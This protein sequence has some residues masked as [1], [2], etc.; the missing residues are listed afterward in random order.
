VVKSVTGAIRQ[1]KEIKGIAIGSEEVRLSL[2][3]DDMVLYIRDSKTLPE[4]F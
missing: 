1:E 3:A 4:N 2:C